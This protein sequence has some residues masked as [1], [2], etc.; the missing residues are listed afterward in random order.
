MDYV[1]GWFAKFRDFIRF[2][3]ASAAFVATN[4]INQGEQVARLWPLLIDEEIRIVFAHTSFKWS[5]LASYNAGVTVAIIG[6]SRHRGRDP[7]I[8]EEDKNGKT[9][10]RVVKNINAY[11]VGYEN[12][13][14]YA[15]LKPISNLPALI[16]GSKPVDG[17][18]LSLDPSLIPSFQT[19]SKSPLNDR[20][21]DTV[22]AKR[23]ISGDSLISGMV[24]MSS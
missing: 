19:T 16:N 23:A 1:C 20:Q 10:I 5:I 6:I 3:N 18:N 12:I 24:G 8:F 21:W 2:C 7:L 17:G 14:V 11:L 15:L 22:S 13:F 4:S 9:T